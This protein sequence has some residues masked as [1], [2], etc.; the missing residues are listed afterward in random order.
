MKNSSYQYTSQKEILNYWEK[1]KFKS[2]RTL[3]ED[4]IYKLNNLK[5][6]IQNL[7]LER[8]KK[9]KENPN[10][11]N[12][13][14]KGPLSVFQKKVRLKIHLLQTLL[15]SR[16][17]MNITITSRYTSYKNKLAIIVKEN[18][19]TIHISHITPKQI[20]FLRSYSLE[21]SKEL[22]SKITDNNLRQEIYTLI[23]YVR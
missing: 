9:Y 22:A 1:I 4:I 23:N 5:S 18:K 6:D 16:K 12:S 3:L 2:N 7:N 21:F 8:I 13:K 11:E 15:S 20:P 19:K 14:E 17:R 10:Y